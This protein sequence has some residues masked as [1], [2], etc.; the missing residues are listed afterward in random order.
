M[1]KTILWTLFFLVAICLLLSQWIRFEREMTR[2]ESQILDLQKD[3]DLVEK[4]RPRKKDFANKIAELKR[5]TADLRRHLPTDPEVEEFLAELADALGDIGLE[6]AS[7]SERS[8]KR[9]FYGET[10]MEIVLKKAS[11]NETRLKKA[12]RKIDRLVR[13]RGHCETRP[14]VFALTIYHVPFEVGP[15]SVKPCVAI[16][17]NALWYLPF[18]GMLR[19]RQ[20]EVSDLC[21]KLSED[22]EMLLLIEQH[23]AQL[24]HWQILYEIDRNLRENENRQDPT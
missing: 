24:E 1:K 15:V 22:E 23:R 20:D 7:H 4:L 17:S 14:A 13:W 11:A 18:T 3:L 5:A 12:L 19:E 2:L 6:I 21:K 9:D 10:R 8:V 16:H